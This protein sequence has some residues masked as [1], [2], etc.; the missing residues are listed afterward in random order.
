LEILGRDFG[1]FK[2]GALRILGWIFYFQRYSICLI[3][4]PVNFLFIGLLFA[5][6]GIWKVFVIIFQKEVQFC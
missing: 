5:G 2:S 6:T 4:P 1:D 3:E